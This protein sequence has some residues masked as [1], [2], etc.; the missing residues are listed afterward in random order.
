MSGK[1]R[2]GRRGVRNLRSFIEIR[3]GVG[4]EGKQGTRVIY[5]ARGGGEGG[6]GVV[7]CWWWW[8]RA[9]DAFYRWDRGQAVDAARL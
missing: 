4:E 9:G 2:A 6:G 1:W 8:M 7:V 3:K 5:L